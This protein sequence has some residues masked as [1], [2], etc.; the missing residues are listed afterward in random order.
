M[1]KPI[2]IIGW[3]QQDPND[4]CY[5]PADKFYIKEENQE[6]MDMMLKATEHLNDDYYL[7]VY[8]KMGG[9]PEFKA[10]YEKDFDEVKF[11]ELKAIIKSAC[12]H[13][14]RTT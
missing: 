14:P 11:E 10:F 7:F 3:P 1:T 13:E 6:S 5:G 12:L 8:S 4:S 9:E 2:F